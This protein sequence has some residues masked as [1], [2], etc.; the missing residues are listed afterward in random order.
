MLRASNARKFKQLLLCA[1]LV[2][3]RKGHHQPIA[4]WIADHGYEMMRVDGSIIFTEDFKKLDRYK[5][6]NIEVVITDLKSISG[7]PSK[8]SDALKEALKR[9]HGTALLLDQDENIVSW[10]STLRM[11]PATG[12][13]LPELDPK[14]FSFNSHKGWC[15]TCR[16][17]GR[18]FPWMRERLEDDE[19]LAKSIGADSNEDDDSDEVTICPDCDGRRLNRT[20]RNVFLRLKGNRKISLPTL[21]QQ[22]PKDLLKTLSTLNLD[23]RGVLLL[24]T[25]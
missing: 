23:E 8:V 25:L 13:A 12:V 10:L 18:I 16:G 20:S 1:P 11:D 5:E 4:N 22:T 19:L 17:H 3:N 6:H 2:R 15:P 7:S 9:G 24:A 21:L 14:D